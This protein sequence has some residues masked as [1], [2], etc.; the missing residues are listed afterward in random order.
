VHDGKCNVLFLGGQIEA[1]TPEQLKQ[2]VDAT[3]AR[4]RQ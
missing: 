4:L 3:L 2:A 1:L